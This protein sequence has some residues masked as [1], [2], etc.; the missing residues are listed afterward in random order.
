[1]TQEK[2][3]N[4]WMVHVNKFRQKHPKLSY[5]EVLQEAKKTYTKKADKKKKGSK[6][7]KP[8]GKKPRKKTV[9]VENK[10]E[11]KMKEV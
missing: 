1:M 8:K 4:P 10:N 7:G 5:K 6:S 3:V 11:H 9:Q 2:K